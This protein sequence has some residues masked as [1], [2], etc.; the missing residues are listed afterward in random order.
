MA[1]VLRVHSENLKIQGHFPMIQA[2]F[3]EAQWK[4]ERVRCPGIQRC[5]GM[6]VQW[7]MGGLG[8]SSFLSL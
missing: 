8:D 5:Q 1:T 4:G 6:R 3:H 2:E 7:V